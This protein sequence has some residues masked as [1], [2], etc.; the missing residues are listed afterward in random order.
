MG[1]EAAGEPRKPRGDLVADG[2]IAVAVG[3]HA[4]A[5]G[6]VD[7][8]DVVGNV[9][10]RFRCGGAAHQR[11]GVNRA[12]AAGTLVHRVRRTADTAE[13]AAE[14]LQA[15]A[16]RAALIDDCAL[17]RGPV[18]KGR[19]AAAHRTRSRNMLT[20]DDNTPPSP[21]SNAIE[22]SRTWRFPARRVICRWV[23]TRWAIAPPTPQW[24]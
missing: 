10:A 19:R 8:N 9:R 20:C 15:P 21:C 13:A 24:P 2:K 18:R 22:A 4:K 6:G 3:H 7:Q 16:G 5:F 23:S 1:N 14:I 11:G 17:A 12:L